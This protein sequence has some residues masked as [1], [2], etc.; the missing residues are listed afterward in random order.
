MSSVDVIIVLLYAFWMT[1]GTIAADLRWAMRRAVFW[2]PL[3]GL[4]LMSF[5]LLVAQKPYL[6]FAELFRLSWIYLLFLYI[7]A[8]VRTKKEISVI[9]SGLGVFAF[10]EFVVVGLQWKTGGV[11]GLGFLGVPKTLTARTLDVGE[12]G[13]PF[14]TLIHPVFLGCVL[15]CIG[16]VALSL[17]INLQE[18]KWRLWSLAVVPLCVIPMGI[19]HTRGP[20]LAF[21]VAAL[22]LASISLA[23][24]RLSLRTVILALIVVLVVVAIAWPAISTIIHE[25]FGTHH[26]GVEVHSRTQLN[27]VGY[28]MF[29]S[30]PLIG[31]GLNNFTQIMNGFLKEPLLFP[32]FPSHNLFILQAAE[33][34]L[35]GELAL[36]LV[37]GTLVAAA[38]KL[39][40]SNDRLFSAIGTAVFC[41]YIFYFV[42]EQLAYSL[43]E[44][45]PLGILWLLAGL[46]V[47][48]LRIDESRRT[49]ARPSARIPRVHTNG[50]NGKRPNGT[51]ANGHDRASSPRSDRA[52][53]R[54]G[55]R[56]TRRRTPV[57]LRLM[58]VF[59]VIPTT[60]VWLSGDASAA[61]SPTSRLQIV[62]SAVERGNGT[63][64]A[65]YEAD[66]DT[67]T[68]HRITPDDGATYSWPT[69][70]M[71]GTKIVYTKRTGATGTAENIFLANPDGS[72]PIQLTHTTW[73]VDQPK[74]SPDGRTVV[75][76]SFWPESPQVSLMKIDLETLEVSN[77]SLIAQ[78]TAPAF[79]SDPSWTP[80][81]R[82]IFSHSLG[83][84]GNVVPTG[85]WTM[86]ADGTEPRPLTNDSFFNVD[87]QLSP[88]G[89]VAA[90][91]SYPRTGQPVDRSGHHRRHPDQDRQLAARDP[92]HA[93]TRDACAHRGPAVR[94][95]PPA[96][97]G[98]PGIRRRTELDPGRQ[99]H[100]LH[101]GPLPHVDLHL[102]DRGRR[103]RSARRGGEQHSGDRLVQLDVAG[104]SAAH[105]RA[106]RP[107]RVPGIEGEHPL[108]RR[109]LDQRRARIRLQR[110]RPLRRQRN[111]NSGRLPTAF[112]GVDAR[113]HEDRVQCAHALR[114][115]PV[116]SVAGA[117]TGPDPSHPLH[118]RSPAEHVGASRAT[119]AG[120]CE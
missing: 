33:T 95:L 4:F 12:I 49:G 29:L 25:N 97:H 51:S 62:F 116:Q 18:R 30:S 85:V 115:E 67:G 77:L 47:A 27:H 80:D 60:F 117:T 22:A 100:R 19:S 119:R 107:D 105:A 69:W 84:T 37:G 110:E 52:P 3:F 36:L 5:S 28:R 21:A 94:R 35:L 111:R 8:R 87:A 75:F 40:R 38:W 39:S 44:E 63:G 118:A 56:P 88:N 108:R 79:D 89:T 70:A 68:I 16:L 103:H 13:R 106:R 10:I 54:N 45:E 23:R 71:N 9:L 42:E 50:T 24:H 120:F 99:A 76:S 31:T 96:L 57:S 78:G 92:R 66:A 6:S 2:V 43:R 109:R 114:P 7:G 113:P 32:G 14:G 61:Q 11:L 53:S 72:N 48:C 20:A 74:V 83:A 82:I 46:T 26:F 59:A 34:G 104:N 90:Y 86:N 64:Q 81:G 112:C 15:A 1:E 73:R 91:A 41:V 101:L 98:H 58:A 93:H 55:S 65:I 102:R 17:A